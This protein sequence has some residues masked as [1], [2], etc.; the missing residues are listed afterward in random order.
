MKPDRLWR[1]TQTERLKADHYILLHEF[2]KEYYCPYCGQK[3][4]TIQE[5]EEHLARCRKG[6]RKIKPNEETYDEE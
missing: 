6:F 2:F 5:F 4:S 3:F 1:H